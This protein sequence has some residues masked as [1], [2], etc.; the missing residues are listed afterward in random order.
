MKLTI[1]TIIMILLIP[2]SLTGQSRISG[3]VTDK[4]SKQ[5]VEFAIVYI[6]GSTNGTLTD[7]HGF[8]HLENV[9]LP[10]TLVVSHLSFV[11]QTKVISAV[12]ESNLAFV[13]ET[14][15]NKID[16]V[17]V[18]DKSLR[19]DNLELFKEKFLGKNSWGKNASIENEDAIRFS[20]DYNTQLVFV[21]NKKEHKSITKSADDYKISDDNSYIT[22]N[23]ATNMM[24]Y[25]VEPLKI[26]LPLLGYTVY[27]DLVEFL[28][29]PRS[30]SEQEMCTIKGYSYFI[31][32]AFESKRDSIRISKNR[33]KCYYNSA[34]HFCR[35]L[36]DDKLEQNGYRIYEAIVD[37]FGLNAVPLNPEPYL[38]RE[39]EYLI[40]T[41]L[42]KK[43]LFISY[44]E[45]RNG[46]PKD[47]N[48]YKEAW[49]V[50]SQI[51]FLKDTCLIGENGTIPGNT[52]VFG[53][54]VG[55]KKVGAILPDDYKPMD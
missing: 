31:E 24:A 5:P 6:N 28:W 44:C 27:L 7:S 22:Q 43:R 16:E 26:E 52:I 19:K 42:N 50:Q 1:H 35:S 11:S 12:P 21:K 30:D 47:L 53:N 17:V 18:T 37:I 49:P 55:D 33:Q 4:Q 40:I 25:S 54:P 10:C 45:E 2:W 13:L 15:L 41:G 3:T 8:F 9:R 34:H 20:R 14:K 38:Q 48:I 29:K 46:K 23:V 51:I 36:Y 32:K 39:G